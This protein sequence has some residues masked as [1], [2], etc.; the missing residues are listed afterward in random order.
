MSRRFYYCHKKEGRYPNTKFLTGLLRTVKTA[1]IVTRKKGYMKLTRPYATSG[2]KG[3]LAAGD[4]SEGT[5]LF[6]KN[7]RNGESEGDESK[8]EGNGEV[9]GALLTDSKPALLETKC[10]L[11]RE[12]T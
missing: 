9:H 6:Y 10:P 4:D 2:V 8:L 11:I 12:E 3:F 5:R 1:I 7:K